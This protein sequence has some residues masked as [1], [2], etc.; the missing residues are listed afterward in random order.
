MLPSERGASRILYQYADSP[1]VKGLILALL[2]EF[3]T[4]DEVFRELE[5]RLDIDESVGE[6]L[7]LIGEIVG[8]PRPNSRNSPFLQ[9]P[10]PEAFAFSGGSGLGFSGVDRPDVGGRF[11]G[12]S[13]T[14]QAM[15]DEDYRVLLKAKIVANTTR[16]TINDSAEYGEFVFGSPV[17]I[18][19]GVGFI[20]VYFQKALRLWERELVRQT[21]PVAAGVR[22]RLK[23]YSLREN[24]FGFAG[25]DSNSGFTDASGSLSGGGFVGLF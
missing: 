21:F 20:D 22:L 24:P 1:K 23:G 3:D 7:D 16:A 4:L 25:N 8:Q 18:I 13:G 10:S 9:F 15:L 17:T 2:D 11:V 12:T 14:A 6:Q 5:T 19:N